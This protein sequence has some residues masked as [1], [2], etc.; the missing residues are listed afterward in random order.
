MRLILFIF[1]LKSLNTFSQ[2][3]T[4]EAV[5]GEWVLSTYKESP[6]NYLLKT[7]NDYISTKKDSIIKLIVRKDSIFIYRKQLFKIDTFAFKY[8]INNGNKRLPLKKFTIYPSKKM[9]KG[10]TRSYR[11]THKELSLFINKISTSQLALETSVF[12]NYF[13]NPFFY[14]S[15]KTYVF[16]KVNPLNTVTEKDFIGSWS[17]CNDFASIF[18]SDTINLMKDTCTFTSS[19][20]IGS[21]IKV[22]CEMNLKIEFSTEFE[23]ENDIWEFKIDKTC[24]IINTRNSSSKS[25][26][27][28][29]PKS[30]RI[31]L[32]ISKTKSLNFNYTINKNKLLLIRNKQYEQEKN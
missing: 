14:A 12:D 3:D 23:Y 9:L 32:Y 11:K 13:V 7:S 4:N 28:I 25:K 2:L 30:K 22:P 17:I 21:N 19:I 8:S 29:N 10:F 31:T 1:I 16:E 27:L 5:V 18:T 26:W 15:N 6:S 24:S 20:T